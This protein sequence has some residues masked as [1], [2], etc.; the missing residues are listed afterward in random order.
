MADFGCFM[1]GA[2]VT[3]SNRAVRFQR[4]AG[5][6]AG[7]FTASMSIAPTTF[8]EYIPAGN[9][10]TAYDLWQN[11]ADAMTT[12]DGTAVQGVYTVTW[13]SDSV[14]G[15]T[16]KVKITN[17]AG[18]DFTILWADA[19]TTAD[20]AWFGCTIASSLSDDTP[21]YASTASSSGVVTSRHTSSLW[22]GPQQAFW[23]H[24]YQ[25]SG[26]AR[27]FQTESFDGS[28]IVTDRL[29]RKHDFPMRTTG[30]ASDYSNVG[31]HVR[32]R[33]DLVEREYV[34]PPHSDGSNDCNQNLLMWWAERASKGGWFLVAESNAAPGFS[35]SIK[36]RTCR[37]MRQQCESFEDIARQREDI[38]SPQFWAIDV[39]LRAVAGSEIAAGG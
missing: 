25:A 7:T 27:V 32:V 1:W 12:A 19:L 3:S 11:L 29:M 5:A 4:T 10:A 39:T 22:W 8:P 34:Y 28:V 18:N 2:N 6:G 15:M 17:S 23:V 31:G 36:Y 16:G 37:L 33:V 26:I 35:T 24:E 13:E 30:Q 20:P 21:T 14:T 9:G 38:A